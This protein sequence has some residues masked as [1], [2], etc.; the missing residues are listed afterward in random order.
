[1]STSPKGE[2]EREKPTLGLKVQ[3]RLGPGLE[4]AAQSWDQERKE[5]RIQQ[6]Q[7]GEDRP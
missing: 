2:K 3:D 7:G 6:V 4:A 1:M 5:A